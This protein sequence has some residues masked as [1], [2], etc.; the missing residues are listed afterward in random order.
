M[1]PRKCLNG[2]RLA[3]AALGLLL[4][5]SVAHAA[6]PAFGPTKAEDI[7]KLN[8]LAKD[9]D[10]A[11]IDVPHWL[12]NLVGFS[13]ELD[14]FPL[15]AHT[16]FDLPD[17]AKL[18]GAYQ[19]LENTKADSG[20]VLLDILARRIELEKLEKK[21]PNLTAEERAAGVKLAEETIEL[22]KKLNPK[23][24][25]DEMQTQQIKFTFKP[26]PERPKLTDQERARIAVLTQYLEESRHGG[27]VE[28][29]K[30]CF[31]VDADAAQAMLWECG[32]F[33]LAFEVA[34][35]KKKEKE[36]R[37]LRQIITRV[38]EDALKR[39]DRT[40]ERAAALWRTAP[41]KK[42]GDDDLPA[43]TELRGPK[44]LDVPE[45]VRSAEKRA[46]DY[47][48]DNAKAVNLKSAEV[49]KRVDNPTGIFFAGEARGDK[50]LPKP[51]S[52]EYTPGTDAA[53]GKLTVTFADDSKR[54]LS[55]VHAEDVWIAHEMIYGADAAKPED[56]I[57]LLVLDG[58]NSY[59]E[60]KDGKLTAV[61][62]REVVS[63]P[64]LLGR[65]LGLACVRMEGLPRSRKWLL[66]EID[67]D[68]VW[69]KMDKEQAE[70]RKQ[71]LRQES[72]W[73]FD[74]WTNL[75]KKFGPHSSV[76]RMTDVPLLIRGGD[77]TLIVE[78]DDPDGRWGEPLRRSTFIV[79]DLIIQKFSQAGKPAGDAKRP[80]N[81]QD[82]GYRLI[83][84]LL[85]TSSELQRLNNF[86][87]VLGVVRWAK[88]ADAKFTAPAKPKDGPRTPEAVAVFT[89]RLLP[90]QG[91]SSKEVL[92]QETDKLDAEI[93]KLAEKES[94]KKFQEICG[95]L[96][97]TEDKEEFD[98]LIKQ[99]EEVSKNA[100]EAR[101]LEDLVEA[102]YAE[103]LTIGQTTQQGKNPD[104]KAE[105][106][107][108]RPIVRQLEALRESSPAEYLI[109]QN[110]VLKYLKNLENRTKVD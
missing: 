102:K 52:L 59:F 65:E 57:P 86:A 66:D 23:Y 46:D 20:G 4:T 71:A 30:R 43:L 95:K 7:D 13:P 53:N 74:P 54:T 85:P 58:P 88:A 84:E 32:T 40:L 103:I 38:N 64:A 42:P 25:L 31:D 11:K 2:S 75:G 62:R 56:G 108:L 105:E 8:K 63:H 35:A 104:L 1:N 3:L 98:K 82:E 81:Y 10:A 109:G 93:K 80:E 77:G 15:D 89:D 100:P 110:L 34:F 47:K 24:K 96:L 61:R 21:L 79:P 16:Y 29:L 37:A 44:F 50:A 91:H 22:F 107:R 33:P 45:P 94:I 18:R 68:P 51:V 60:V 73:L 36:P 26:V 72:D 76:F 41:A 70:R 6:E 39:D 12:R 55:P 49:R 9:L 92:K 48:K 99:L 90:L 14:G 97:N 83:A 101:L 78:R 27:P 5:L 17:V 106:R 19:A 69:A 28:A 87:A 67:A